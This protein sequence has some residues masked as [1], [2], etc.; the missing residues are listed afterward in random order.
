MVFNVIIVLAAIGA[1]AW[2][3]QARKAS[4]ARQSEEG[5]EIGRHDHARAHEIAKVQAELQ[6][7]SGPH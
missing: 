1:I 7:W 5:D 6:R 4:V 3:Y 2:W